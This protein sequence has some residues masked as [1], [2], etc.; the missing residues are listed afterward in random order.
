VTNLEN[1]LHSAKDELRS[2]SQVRV[3]REMTLD[4]LQEQLKAKVINKSKI[5]SIKIR[6]FSSR[7]MN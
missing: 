3:K 2:E 1:A 6:F 5:K 4:R 7:K